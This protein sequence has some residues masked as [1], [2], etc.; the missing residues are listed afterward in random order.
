MAN[1][2]YYGAKPALD[3]ASQIAAVANVGTLTAAAAAGS[4]PT[5]AEFD[6]AVADLATLRTK[7]NDLLTKMRTSDLLDT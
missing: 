3:G 6:A 4:T 1:A 5:K 2:A 7:L